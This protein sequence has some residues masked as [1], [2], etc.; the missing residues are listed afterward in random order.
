[1]ECG[2]ISIQRRAR[3]NFPKMNLHSRVKEWHRSFFYCKD[4]SPE[5]EPPLP[6]YR[7]DRLVYS[8][9]LNSWPTIEDKKELEPVLEQ[10]NALLSHG[11]SAIDLVKC[12]VG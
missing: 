10:V 4:I 5:D 8:P 7:E 9:I 3:R 12:W 2:A 1:M 11:L 6:G